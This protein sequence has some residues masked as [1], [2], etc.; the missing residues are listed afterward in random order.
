MVVAVV[1]L[2]TAM[3]LCG[4]FSRLFFVRVSQSWRLEGDNDEDEGRRGR[5]SR[6]ERGETRERGQ[7]WAELGEDD[8]VR[9]WSFPT[10]TSTHLHVGGGV[11]SSYCILFNSAQ[12]RFQSGDHC[13]GQK[14]IVVYSHE[15]EQS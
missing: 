12:S 4:F 2:G 6:K 13:E 11:S 1:Y 3:W 14:L 5:K 9:E 7:P 15:C 8:G 10:T